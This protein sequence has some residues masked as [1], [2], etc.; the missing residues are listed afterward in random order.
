MKNTINMYMD[1]SCHTKHDKTNVMSLVTVYTIKNNVI[2]FDREIEN[3]KNKYK[4]GGEVKWNKVSPANI[5][6]YKEIISLL[7]GYAKENKIR[8]RALLI[9]ADKTK[10]RSEYSAWYYKMVY[11]LFEKIIY[12]D[13][14]ENDKYDTFNL[15]LDKK[16]SDS[17]KESIK[18]ARYLSNKIFNQ[19]TV[20]GMAVDSKEHYLIQIADIISGALTYKKRALNTSQAKLDLI[21]HI[22]KEFSLNLN[23]T[24]TLKKLDFN[25]LVWTDRTI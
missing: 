13:F 23:Q 2:L 21:S 22:E 24:T 3:I 17:S 15:F 6:F 10:I 9:S 7:S 16:D 14:N 11:L 4:I 5:N 8:V 25:L 20:N 18:T 1:E 12:R 19:K